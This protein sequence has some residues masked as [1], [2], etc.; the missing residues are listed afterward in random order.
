MI[1]CTLQGSLYHC[2]TSI[3]ATW[4]SYYTLSVHDASTRY[5]RGI[6]VAYHLRAG[7]GRPAGVLQRP[8]QSQAMTVTRCCRPG[9]ATGTSHWHWNSRLALPGFLPAPCLLPASAHELYPSRYSSSDSDHTLAISRHSIWA[10]WSIKNFQATIKTLHEKVFSTLGNANQVISS[11]SWKGMTC[12]AV[13]C[14]GLLYS[15]WLSI[16]RRFLPI[17]SSLGRRRL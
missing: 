3:H 11:H 15:D 12:F 14:F 10:S 7:V 1:S 6:C 2:T 8:P 9:Q 13:Q 4:C 17:H 5:L 16:L